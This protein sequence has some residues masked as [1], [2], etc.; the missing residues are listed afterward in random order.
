MLLGLG[1]GV[2]RAEARR[3]RVVRFVE[4]KGAVN[5]VFSIG[6][7]FDKQLRQQIASGFQKVV[8][9][10]ARV[11]RVGRKTPMAVAVRSAKVVYDL[12]G[13]SYRITLDDAGGRRQVRVNRLRQAVSV[14]SAVSLVLGPL[15]RFPPRRGGRG[16]MFYADVVVQ[17][18]PLPPGFL[19]KIRRWLQRPYGAEDGSSSSLG[20]RFS[21]FVNPRISRALK[22]WRF[23]TQRFYRE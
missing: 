8:L 10:E 5:M 19:R 12:W 15:A 13:D 9:V 22:E 1:A 21:L 16:P 6:R 4:A 2:D 3:Y 11:Y 14:L 23:R 18:A 7:F 20:S 17:F